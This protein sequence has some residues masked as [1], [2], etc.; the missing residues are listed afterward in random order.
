MN[1]YHQQI[2]QSVDR[3]VGRSDSR[4]VSVTMIVSKLG[5]VYNHNVDYKDGDNKRVMRISA[6]QQLGINAEQDSLN[7]KNKRL[8]NIA[9]PINENDAINLKHLQAE[10]D[11]LRKSVKTNLDNV[12]DSTLWKTPEMLRI[13]NKINHLINITNKLTMV[14]IKDEIRKAFKIAQ[15]NL[16]VQANRL[17]KEIDEKIL[18]ESK[19]IHNNLKLTEN[20]F[21]KRFDNIK[22]VFDVDAKSGDVT[23]INY[24]DAQGVQ[25]MRKISNVRYGM[26]QNDVVNRNVLESSLKRTTDSIFKTFESQ[27]YLDKIISNVLNSSP[28]TIIDKNKDLYTIKLES[29]NLISFTPKSPAQPTGTATTTTATTTP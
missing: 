26:E 16:D 2:S 25:Q 29:A 15:Q 7:F 14:E 13:T 6:E 18:N 22:S 4:S 9:Q 23:L 12:I 10:L 5:T 8:T 1:R 20:R 11:N 17:S 3:S 27:A 21:E 28:V 19:N 24:T